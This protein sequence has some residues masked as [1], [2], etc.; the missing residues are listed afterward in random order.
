MANLK[1]SGLIVEEIEKLIDTF[2]KLEPLEGVITKD[3]QYE[4]NS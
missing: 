4:L 3:F 2:R 1:L